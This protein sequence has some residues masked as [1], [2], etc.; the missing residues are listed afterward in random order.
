MQSLRVPPTQDDVLNRGG[1]PPTLDAMDGLVADAN[2]VG[3]LAEM[4]DPSDGSFWGNLPQ[5]LSHLA[6]VTAAL[7]I[8]ELTSTEGH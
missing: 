2:D 1:D 3:L 8:D 5:G 4:I 6:L 7:T